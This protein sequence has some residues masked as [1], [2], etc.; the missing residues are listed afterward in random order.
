[1]LI[2]TAGFICLILLGLFILL[3]MTTV[4]MC[5]KRSYLLPSD[6]FKYEIIVV[7]GAHVT[8][9]EPCPEL[10]SR[11]NHALCLHRMTQKPIAVSGGFSGFTSETNVMYDYL[12][13]LGMDSQYLIHL[14]PG[15]STTSTI[16]S[17]AKYEHSCRWLA[18]S[19]PYH[20]ARL[21]YLAF[22]HGLNICVCCPS[23][24]KAT[25][26]Y[27]VKQR[28]RETMAILKQICLDSSVLSVRSH[29]NPF[30]FWL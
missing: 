20:S 2:I 21:H 11:L 6:L 24:A 22:R 15:S 4:W 14:T 7:L 9:N 5:E 29:S 13:A 26:A 19:S 16:S 10:A 30:R 12:K 18:V 1:M 17:M 27:L 8:A 23:L 25:S 28:L 3:I